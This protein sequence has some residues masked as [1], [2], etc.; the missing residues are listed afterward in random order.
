MKKTIV[1][2]KEVHERLRKYKSAKS[3]VKDR[4]LSYEE[5]I[6]ELLDDDEAK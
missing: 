1:V 2:S 6:V 3:A 5:A 4:D